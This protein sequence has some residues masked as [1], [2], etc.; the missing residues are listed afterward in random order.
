MPCVTIIISKPQWLEPQKVE[1]YV[2]KGGLWL[3]SAGLG[4]V[5]PCLFVCCTVDSEDLGS[6]L[7]L[8]SAGWVALGELLELSESGPS[9][10]KRR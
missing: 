9:V 2:T 10:V 7:T 5:L 8:S 3:G 4:A 6:C 1:A